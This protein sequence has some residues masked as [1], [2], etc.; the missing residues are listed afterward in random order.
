VS[1][2]DSLLRFIDPIEHR[3]REANRRRARDTR[4]HQPDPETSVSFPPPQAAMST[5]RQCRVCGHI[6][7]THFCLRCLADTM[8]DAP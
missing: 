6:D 2:M 8:E 4:A 7:V 3:E 5:R 1:L